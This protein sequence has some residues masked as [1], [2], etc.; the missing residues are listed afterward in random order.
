MKL[1]QVVCC[2][3]ELR[4]LGGVWCRVYN[5]TQ[6]YLNIIINTANM[7]WALGGCISSLSLSALLLYWLADQSE[8][9]PKN[10][11]VLIGLD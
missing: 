4:E 3:E 11:S 1:R 5:S 6:Y 8:A 7:S 10:V 2:Q 9:S